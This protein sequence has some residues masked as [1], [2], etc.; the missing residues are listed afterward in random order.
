MQRPLEKLLLLPAR[1][2]EVPCDAVGSRSVI[3]AAELDHQAAAA[4]SRSLE[5]N[6]EHFQEARDQLEQWADD[7]VLVGGEGAR[8]TRRSTSRCSRR[9]ARG[10]TTLDEQHEIQER[11]KKLERQQ[12][13]QRQE[14]FEVEDEIAERRD[15]LIDA[16][17]RRLAQGSTREAL[18]TV[19]F[20]VV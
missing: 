17:E 4:L 19:E 13:R 15:E 11:I 1:L 16:L 10:A 8:Q 9:E 14:I 2:A 20:E 6:S 12:R 3:F 5:M 7:M 18:F